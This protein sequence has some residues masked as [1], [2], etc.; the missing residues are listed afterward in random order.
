M[1][2]NVK[3]QLQTHV[4]SSGKL[5]SITTW[6]PSNKAIKHVFMTEAVFHT[7]RNSIR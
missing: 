2:G 5:S 3:E 1:D 4:V 6:S 7:L